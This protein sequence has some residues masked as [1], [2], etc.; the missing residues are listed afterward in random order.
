MPRLR[1]SPDPP[2][3][4]ALITFRRRLSIGHARPWNSSHSD[5]SLRVGRGGGGFIRDCA[6][7]LKQLGAPTVYSPP[8]PRDQVPVWKRAGFDTAVELALLSLD[9]PSDLGP[10]PMAI[11]ETSDLDALVAVDEAAFGEFW[12]F[13]SNGIAEARAA[14]KRGSIFAVG[15]PPVAYA[16]VGYGQTVSYLQRVAVAPLHQGR[17]IGTELVAKAAHEATRRGA[18]SLF[19]N[20]QIEN[21]GA[22]RL[23]A[24]LGFR[25]LAEGLHL[26]KR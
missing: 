13:D 12:A 9:L 25:R 5:A 4:P 22:L 11:A 23:Y 10:P 14:T 26:M 19:L 7:A 8:L 1:T 21:D 17:G 3:W 15:D 6:K 18:R 20:T 24:R 16:V 2:D